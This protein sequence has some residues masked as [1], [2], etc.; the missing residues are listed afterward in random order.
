MFRKKEAKEAN[1]ELIERNYDVILVFIGFSIVLLGVLNAFKKVPEEFLFGATLSGFFF[2]FSDYNLLKD[3]FYQKDMLWNLISLFLG[4]LSFFLLPIILLVF[5]GMYEA[6]EPFGDAATF[7]ALGFIVVGIGI[8]SMETKR[9][10]LDLI[11]LKLVDLN[12]KLM[13]AT[14]KLEK[15]ESELSQWK[16]KENSKSDE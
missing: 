14:D 1:K 3:R 16:I 13:E 12:T 6:V 5:P 15:A 9:K 4:V 10:Y 8:K 11:D 2:A 7:L